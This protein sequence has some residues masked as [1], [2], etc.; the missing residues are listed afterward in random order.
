MAETHTSIDAHS[1]NFMQWY[2]KVSS[3]VASSNRY[4]QQTGESFNSKE[5]L[6]Q[7]PVTKAE[8]HTG[9]HSSPAL[10]SFVLL[11][12]DSNIKQV[13]R[14]ECDIMRTGT[15]QFDFK[16][17]RDL[18]SLSK[19]VDR[20]RHFQRYGPLAVLVCCQK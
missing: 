15:S 9:I 16:D 13:L 2:D 20:S 8:H 19:Y 12:W 10:F 6:R 17:K 1:K 14:P 11:F 3:T 4:W 5:T 18:C 7:I